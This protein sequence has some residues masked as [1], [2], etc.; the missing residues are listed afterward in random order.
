MNK[1]SLA[2]YDS[3]DDRREIWRMLHA[4]SP[5]RRAEFQVW[6]CRVT[7][8]SSQLD[9]PKFRRHDDGLPELPNGMRDRLAAAYKSDR[10]DVV[11]T[12]ECYHDIIKLCYC[13]GLD[14]DAATAALGRFVRTGE[15][16]PVPSSPSPPPSPPPPAS[17]RTPCTFWT[18]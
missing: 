9:R 12:N 8:K 6:C 7:G 17:P 5:A 13:H 11:F 16:P 2:D 3:L 10:D 15:L 1:P 18:G 4:L 14:P